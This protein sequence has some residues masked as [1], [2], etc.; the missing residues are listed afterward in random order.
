MGTGHLPVLQPGQKVNERREKAGQCAVRFEAKAG[1]GAWLSHNF[2]GEFWARYGVSELLFPWPRMGKNG[3]L[4]GVSL[5]RE[6]KHE[7][8]FEGV[9]ST[10]LWGGACA[11]DR[12]QAEDAAGNS[13]TVWVGP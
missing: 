9:R 12:P 11:G 2:L 3:C 4:M 7:S 10:S 6:Q 5:A 1:F 13:R 8:P